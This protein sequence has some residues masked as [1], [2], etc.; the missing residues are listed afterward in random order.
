MKHP[1]PIPRNVHLR[2][3]IIAL[4]VGSDVVSE[5]HA[6]IVFGDGWIERNW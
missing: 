6:G 1:A 5:V 4:L 2:E 3:Q